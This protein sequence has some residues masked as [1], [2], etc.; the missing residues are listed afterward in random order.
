M[1]TMKLSKSGNAVTI[2]DDQGNVYMAAV[3]A[4]QMLLNKQ[5]NGGLLIMSRMP[6]KIPP[7]KFKISPLFDPLGLAE[8][9]KTQEMGDPLNMDYKALEQKKKGYEDKNIW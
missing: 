1:T 3:K 9:G 6:N 5:L 8:K 2:V 7:G 4:I